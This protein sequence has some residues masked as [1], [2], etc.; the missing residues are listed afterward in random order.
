MLRTSLLTIALGLIG[1]TST[2]EVA[3]ADSDEQPVFRVVFFTPSDVEPPDGVRGRLKEYVD[4]SQK[5]FA[6]WMVH[7]N[8]KC[9]SP[10]QVIRDDEGYPEILF[11]KGRHTEAS[12]RYRKPDFQGEVVDTACREYKLNPKGQV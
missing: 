3:A 5:F 4:Y 11:V 7:W 6:R 2:A 12:G 10:L 8:Y 9:D 1:A